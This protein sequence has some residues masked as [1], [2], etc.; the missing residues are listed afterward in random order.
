M[1]KK[2]NWQFLL[3][4]CL[5]TLF[6]GCGTKV[7]RMDVEEGKDLSGRWNDTDSRLVAEEMIKDC[8]ERPWLNQYN[9]KTGKVPDVI[10]GNIANRSAEHISTE[11]FIKDLER[12]LLNS[13][14]VRFVASAG[15]RQ[16]IRSE[17]EDQAIN[18]TADS[19]NA[20]RQEAGADF[21]LIG[22]INSIIDR[23]KKRQVVFYQV[24]LEL[25]DMADNRKVWIGNKKIKKFVER[26]KFGY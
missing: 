8:L 7:T 14:K 18:A 13:G 6:A 22:S 5:V 19:A 23:E 4:L 2:M 11:T 1:L 25:I 9:M 3:I 26:S 16:G 15:E 24:D 20:P 21:M 17:R 12:S 10:V